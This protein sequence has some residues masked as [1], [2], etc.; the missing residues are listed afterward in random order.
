MKSNNRGVIFRT[1][2]LA[3]LLVCATGLVLFASTLL[4]GEINPR[5]YPD[6]IPAPPE[7]LRAF[8]VLTGENGDFPAAANL[9]AKEQQAQLDEIVAFAATYGFNTIL[10]EAMPEGDAFYRSKH[11]PASAYWMGK[12]GSF[13]FFDPLYYLSNIAKEKNIRVY[14][15]VD[16]FSLSANGKAENAPAAKHPDWVT[17]DGFLNPAK[18]EV[19]KLLAGVAQELTENY[20]I[21]GV[22]LHEVSDA[23]FDTI[24]DYPKTLATITSLMENQLRDKAAQQIGAVLPADSANDPLTTALLTAGKLDFAI[25]SDLS[26]PLEDQDTLRE[27]LASWQ[28]ATQLAQTAFYTNHAVS[29]ETAFEHRVDNAGY[30]EKQYGADGVVVSGYGSLNTEARIA[31]ISLAASFAQ[32]PAEDMP[33]LT[34]PQTFAITRPTEETRLTSDWQNY[35]IYGTSDPDAPVLLNGQELE[36]SSGGLWDAYVTLSY[37]KNTFSFTQNGVTKTAVIYRAEPGAATSTEMVKSSIYPSAP[38]IVLE[39]DRLKL[40]CTAP[41]GGAVTASV[42][43]LTAQLTAPSAPKGSP[44]TYQATL[45]VNTLAP[46]GQVKGLGPVSYQLNY[47]GFKSFQQSAGSVYAVGKGAVPVAK[48]NSFGSMVNRNP[49][50]DGQYLS[51]LRKDCVAVITQNV[52]SYYKLSMGG[53][54]PKASVDIPEGENTATAKVSKIAIQQTPKAEKLVISN[55]RRPSYVGVLEQNALTLTIADTIGWDTMN[56]LA[57]KGELFTA[58]RPEINEDGSVTLTIE[59]AEHANLLGWDVA[60]EGDDMIVSLRR[61]PVADLSSARP[62]AGVQVVLDPGHGNSDPGALG[63]PGQSGSAEKAFNLANS[64]SLQ[65]RLE[66]FGAEVYLVHEDTADTSLNAR[67]EFAQKMD[68]DVFISSHHNSVALSSNGGL[69]SGIEVYYWNDQSADFAAQIGENLSTQ[70]GR[71]IRNIEQ[72][73]YRVTMMT[74]CPAVLVESGFL[75]NPTE[76]EELAKPFSMFRYGNAV[77]DAVLAYFLPQP[78]ELS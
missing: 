17:A 65:A 73:F 14:A 55:D 23:R 39:G 59:L 35:H 2:F 10:F 44:V 45:D 42:G 46:A 32:R 33:E 24:S 30:F 37:G 53:Y 27:Q 66:A 60:F 13:T 70:S 63:I 78:T 16:P 6:G 58:I 18:P 4:T 52:G 9:S 62:L 31:A 77:A 72:S 40:S 25:L 36:R 43:G 68:A 15:L 8:T 76:Y 12:Q 57:L 26:N 67:L 49:E 3:L 21:A 47:D 34:F 71:A 75:C 64:R 29:D 5:T 22:V 74:S 41:A 54:I 48:T 50:N 1:L 20:D 51:I 38:E 11:L 28:T 61:R 56:P 7:E 69:A 19:Q